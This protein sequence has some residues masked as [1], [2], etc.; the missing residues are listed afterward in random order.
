MIVGVPKEIKSQE[1]R[2]GLVPAG[3][4]H[5]IQSGAQ[6]VVQAGA[7][8][9]SGIEDAEFEAVGATVLKSAEE[10]WKTSDMIIKVKEPLVK[11][12]DLMKKGQILYTYLHLAVVP[13]LAKVFI[14][15]KITSI[16]YETIQLPNHSLPLLKPMSEVAGKMAVQIGSAYLQKEN[17]G[18]GVLL[19]GVPGVRRGR[20]TIIGAGVVGMN[21]CKIAVGMGADVTVIDVNLDRLEYF[22]DIF[23]NKIQT[24]KSHS[25]NIEESVLRA[26]LL[27]GAVL[28]PGAKAPKLVTKN[29]VSKMSPGSVIVDVAVDQ[30]GCVETCKPTT[31][32]DPTFLVD[33]V[34]HY[35]VANMPGAV[36]MSSTIALTNATLAYA[37]KIVEQG[38]DK[39]IRSDVDLAKG[40]NTYNGFVTHRAVADAL[41]EPY[42]SLEAQIGS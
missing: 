40:V 21:A 5:L 10:V 32:D 24:L 8:I 31:H 26:D 7:G 36:A 15:K 28:I 38:V 4:R 25:Q 30:G 6:V 27:I 19:G 16:A 20:V 35:C 3:A 23:G 12:Y 41:N 9:G 22:D 11:E 14:E 29:L 42:H 13:D 34:I 1:Y 18:K 37:K 39:A 2:V 17:G 33:G